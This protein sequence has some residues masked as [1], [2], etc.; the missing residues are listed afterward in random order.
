MEDIFQGELEVE[1]FARA[2]KLPEEI[3]APPNMV[4]GNLTRAIMKTWWKPN[5]MVSALCA[6]QTIGYLAGGNYKSSTGDR[7]NLQQVVIG[8][9]G[10]GKD[11]IL[12]VTTD[13]ISQ[14]FKK[15][16]SL[17]NKLLKGIID[18]AGSPEGLDYR[19]RS[20]KW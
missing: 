6:R 2:K 11:P 8:Y 15:E 4:I 14:C 20:I 12:N 7:C 1:E 9:S 18:D 19:L 13:V 10:I 3:L 17:M 16:P 5:L